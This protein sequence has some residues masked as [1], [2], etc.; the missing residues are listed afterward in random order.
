MRLMDFL[1]F[2]STTKEKNMTKENKSGMRSAFTSRV[3]CDRTLNVAD[4]KIEVRQGTEWV[5]GFSMWPKDAVEIALAVLGT[6]R[7]TE[8]VEERALRRSETQGI[9]TTKITE[10]DLLDVVVVNLRAI[11]LLRERTAEHA[12]DA[13]AA[14]AL[15]KLVHPSSGISQS[16]F[17]R[18]GLGAVYTRKLVGLRGK[19]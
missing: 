3:N 10:E 6:E 1:L 2:K 16:E 12:Q 14:F 5:R 11:A 9:T 15:Y 8:D 4:G 13:E 19:A 7:V 18:E 17:V